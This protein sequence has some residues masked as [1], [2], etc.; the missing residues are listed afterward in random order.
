[1]K[2]NLLSKLLTLFCTDLL[3]EAKNLLGIQPVWSTNMPLILTDKDMP[4]SIWLTSYKSFFQPIKRPQTEP[5]A[6][7]EIQS[8]LLIPQRE[9]K[10][11]RLI[12]IF[13][14][15]CNMTISWHVANS[16]CTDLLPEAKNLLGIHK[17]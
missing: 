6:G 13:L 2:D 1:M 7:L 8:I 3:P 11:L 12:S 15:S 10:H 9:A 14:V 5:S 16:F 4:Y 17:E